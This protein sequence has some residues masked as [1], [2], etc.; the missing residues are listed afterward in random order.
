VN[1]DRMSV[2]GSVPL[3]NPVV[4]APMAGVTD[5]VYRSICREM[6]AGLVCG[7]MV[8]AEGVVHNNIRTRALL[9]TTAREHPV[10]IQVFGA[11]PSS[12]V[13]AAAAAQTEGADIVDVNAGCPTP[14]IVRNRAGAALLEDVPRLEAILR[15]VVEE[16]RRPVTVKLRAGWNRDSVNVVEVAKRAEQCGVAAITVHPRTREQMFRGTADWR[17]IDRVVRAVTVPV[18]GNGDVRSPHDAARMIERTG[19]AAVMIGR[20]AMGRPWILGRTAAYLL[21]GEIPPEPQLD[22]RLSLLERHIRSAVEVYGEPRACR[23]MRK[24]AAWYLREIPNAASMRK[25]VY[26]VKSIAGY[27]DVIENVRRGADADRA[28]YSGCGQSVEEKGNAD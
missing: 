28:A 16:T 26:T 3:D 9:R 27:L 13:R 1:G 21:T 15:A 22:D 6:G 20:A 17:L 4:L 8:S 11:R 2:I 12:M 5:T 24:H 23:M 14:K 10:S 7:E 19:C 18:I 25:M